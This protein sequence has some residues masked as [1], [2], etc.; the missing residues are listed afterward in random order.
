M[1]RVWKKQFRGA[2]NVREMIPGNV[3]VNVFPFPF[4][5]GDNRGQHI[6]ALARIIFWVFG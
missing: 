4:T 3:W 2:T 5:E 6:L 1:C